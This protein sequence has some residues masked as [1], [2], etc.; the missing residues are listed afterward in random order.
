MGKSSR[1]A[2][3][4]TLVENERPGRSSTSGGPVKEAD[5]VVI[6]AG[7]GG[8]CCGAVLAKYGLKVLLRTATAE[9]KRILF[10]VLFYILLIVLFLG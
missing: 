7:I 9:M 1:S 8:L 6:G 3:R 5:V 2:C 4:A 10:D